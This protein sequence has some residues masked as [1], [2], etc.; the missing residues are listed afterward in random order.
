MH[1]RIDPRSVAVG[2]LRLERAGGQAVRQQAL[3]HELTE[4]TA[5][6][7]RAQQVL[8][9][10]DVLREIADAHALLAERAELARDV[11]ELTLGRRGLRHELLFGRP[12][13]ALELGAQ[14]A[15]G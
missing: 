8:Q 3:E 9:R 4:P 7:R 10:A 6:L 1:D 12:E 11:G 15:K 14:L 5:G 2:E 13:R